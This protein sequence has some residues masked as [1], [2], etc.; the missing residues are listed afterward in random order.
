MLAIAFFQHFRDYIPGDGRSLNSAVPSHCRAACPRLQRGNLFLRGTATCHCSSAA[1]A[2]SPWCRVSSACSCGRCIIGGCCQ[3]SSHSSSFSI[4]PHH[5]RWLLNV[6]S[7]HKGKRRINLSLWSLARKYKLLWYAEVRGFQFLQCFC[8]CSHILGRQRHR[9]QHAVAEVLFPACV[10]KYFLITSEQS[11]TLLLEWILALNYL[12][13]PLTFVLT[14]ELESQWMFPIQ[15]EKLWLSNNIC[16]ITSS[17]RL[18]DSKQHGSYCI[19]C[20]TMNK[21]H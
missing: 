5:W 10:Q 14:E 4:S 6:V 21:V 18:N 1:C 7:R 9:P 16:S 8:C 12:W 17:S 15:P 19:S 2:D 11:K 13:Y 3:G 20:H